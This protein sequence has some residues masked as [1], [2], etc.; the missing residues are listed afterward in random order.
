MRS[1]ALWGCGMCYF[2]ARLA[3][4]AAQTAQVR[5]LWPLSLLP[6]LVLAA[7][8]AWLLVPAGGDEAQAV[9]SPVLAG[10]DLLE[11][12]GGGPTFMDFST[13]PIPADFFGPGSDPFIG[14]VQL[15]G[16]PFDSFGGF[17]GLDPTD[18]IIQRLQDAGPSFPD[19]I[20]IEIVALSLVST[21][22]ITVTYNGGQNPELWDLDV[23]VPEGDPNQASGS[24]TV[25]H[26]GANGGTFDSYLPV[27]P[28][29]TFTRV[30]D[31]YTFGS[32]YYSDITRV[33]I[34]FYSQDVP[35]CHTANPLANP[36]GQIVIEKAGLTTNFFPGITCEP[37][38]TKAFFSMIAAEAVHAVQPAERDAGEVVDAGY[39]LLETDGGGPTFMDFAN[40]PI[41]ADFFGPG[42]DP[43]NGSAQLEGDPFDSFGGFNGLVPTDAIVQRLQD[44]GP[45]GFPDTID[46][47][48]VAL[49]L[50]SVSPITV[51]FNGGQN[52][53]L[54]DLDVDVPEGD[55]N[56]ASGSMTVRHEGANGGTFDAVLP[57]KPIFT[58]TKVDPPNQGL[59][60]VLDTHLEGLPPIQFQATGENWCH[61][62]NPLASPPGHVVIEKAGLTTNFFPGI[63][64][65]PVLTK[66]YFALIGTLFAQ[67]VA[68]HA[69]QPAEV[70]VP[71]ASLDHYTWY[72]AF[73]P[74]GPI[75]TLADQFQAQ[76]V[77]LGPVIGF[78][79]PADK[80]GEGI[81]N[82]DDHLTCYWIPEGEFGAVVEVMNQFGPQTL[83]VGN[84]NSLCVPTEKFPGPIPLPL[85]LDH[86]KCY[87][88]F[89]PPVLF[90]ATL[91]DQFQP[92]AV[93]VMD[94][95][96]FCN[97]VDKNGEGITNPDGHLTCHYT[98]PPGLPIGP[99]PVR[100]QFHEDIVDVWEPLGLCVPSSK[101]SVTLP[102]T[103]DT[104]VHDAAHTNI[105][106]TTVT[107]D[108]T[109]VV[110]DQVTVSGTG[111][112]P[113][114][115]VTFQRFSTGDC[116]GASTDENNVPL[117]AGTADST[118]FT[119]AVGHYSYLVHYDGDGSYDP[120]DGVCEPFN[121]IPP[122]LPPTGPHWSC[123]MLFDLNMPGVTVDV[124]TQFSFE[125][126]ME[127]GP[128]TYLCPPALKNGEGNPGDPHLECFS[129]WPSD[130][131]SY[132][133]NLNTQFGYEEGV[134]VGQAQLLCVPAVKTPI[135]PPGP[136][137]GPLV[138]SPHY[139]C[140]SITGDIL[141]FPVNV[142]DQFNEPSGEDVILGQAQLL[143]A[144]AIKT[145]DGPPEGD[146]D[147]WPHLKCYQTFI[148]PPFWDVDLLTQ[149]GSSPNFVGFGE[150]LCMPAEKTIVSG[151]EPGPCD[152][153]PT[154]LVIPDNTAAGISDTIT[155]GAS[156]TIADL[157]VCVDIPHTWVGDVKVTL[158]HMS[159]G[160][161][162]DLIDRPGDIPNPPSGC[163]GDDIEA[164]LN[165]E[166]ASDVE[167]ECGGGTPTIQ[168]GFTPNQGLT[169]FDGEDING[170]WKLTVTDNAGGFLVGALKGWNLIY[171]T[172]P[173][174]EPMPP[175]NIPPGDSDCDG[176]DDADEIFIGTDPNNPC[177]AGAWAV[178]INDTQGVDIFDVLELAPPVFF[179]V[180]PGP[181]YQ[182]RF[183]L[184]P[185]GG[186]DIFDVL[187]MAP[188]VF[189]ATCTP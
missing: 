182:A 77:D 150:L 134:E 112:T 47:E 53:E 45:A 100:N 124:E 183:D 133:V 46:I 170:D 22:P 156:G 5:S 61:D 120:G 106:N 51:T 62:A 63:N 24:M 110:H 58:F 75:V 50:K 91:T 38:T 84:P 119:P 167:S 143:C 175:W 43:F 36:P 48:I 56:Q 107:Q 76:V 138:S 142:T 174:V 116:T 161:M 13:G 68:V 179:S 148:N 165:D 164:T 113:T 60:L 64:C 163:S 83:D 1:A 72:D 159:T 14:S 18:T 181:P 109:L 12:D 155:I 30:S 99:I 121:V 67:P 79:P 172:G 9:P 37:V 168:G 71:A 55:P 93:T 10:Y 85:M 90:P 16:D 28:Q 94:P 41:P 102:S 186:I 187:R 19:T 118:A 185:S 54:W 78:L 42:S 151:H 117:V 73:G 96:L 153:L 140:Y 123:Y 157:N 115:T 26:E 3:G 177:G 171:G 132:V 25:R 126:D 176:H 166:A 188:P 122:P 135:N 152:D 8:A 178:D 137:S 154:P 111:P 27:D 108:G 180:A 21:A 114:G 125:K 74:V 98:E 97:P 136:P 160:T 141:G 131:P 66:N 87:D 139:K 95:F 2:R 65:E 70:P 15:E 89:G 32:I 11:T 129:I 144:P 147:S 34:D 4:L 52:P 17:N 105:T 162:I 82:P 130:D 169:A 6:F 20:D 33:P 81:T 104:E 69:V 145:F 149:F 23:D 80:N 86:Y 35:W 173:C 128:S 127:V 44:A 39:D 59:Q 103:V 88:A 184:N 158:T 40:A 92:Q 189:F 31:A 7:L 29:L 101:E 49:S 146:L 57:V